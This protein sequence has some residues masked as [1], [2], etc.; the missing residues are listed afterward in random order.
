[1]P[2]KH[3]YF[4]ASLDDAVDL[5]VADLGVAARSRPVFGRCGR[6]GTALHDAVDLDVADLD[7]ATRSRPVF[8]KRGRSG[9]ASRIPYVP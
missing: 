8:C 4:T 1:M 3:F 2:L 9:T 5:D 7:V 6:S